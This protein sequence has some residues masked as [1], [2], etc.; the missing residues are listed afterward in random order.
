MVQDCEYEGP[1]YGLRKNLRA[2]KRGTPL[3]LRLVC[4]S[5]RPKFCCTPNASFDFR[6]IFEFSVCLFAAQSRDFLLEKRYTTHQQNSKTLFC[7]LVLVM[8]SMSAV[9]SVVSRRKQACRFYQ[10][11][12]FVC[13]F[14][15][16]R[17][18]RAHLQRKVSGQLPVCPLVVGLVAFQLFQNCFPRISVVF[19][20]CFLVNK[21]SFGTDVTCNLKRHCGLPLLLAKKTLP[22]R[23]TVLFCHS[24]IVELLYLKKYYFITSTIHIF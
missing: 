5:N 9:I 21:N 2:A 11:F 13:R 24:L 1:H 19:A 23:L 12:Y 17:T 20:V 18:W 14:S 6:A 8:K 22:F 10:P 15:I 4:Y 16:L 7:F 3:Q